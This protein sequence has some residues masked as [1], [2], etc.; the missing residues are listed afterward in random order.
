[1][2]IVEGKTFLCMATQIPNA[3]SNTEYFL[4]CFLKLQD[5]YSPMIILGSRYKEIKN[6][7]LELPSGENLG[8]Q[9]FSRWRLLFVALK[10]NLLKTSNRNK[11]KRILSYKT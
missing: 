11:M 4:I 10:L 3:R 8:I 2:V 5:I 9:T 7:Q 1:M 6:K